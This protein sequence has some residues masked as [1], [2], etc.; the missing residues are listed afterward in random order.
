MVKCIECGTEF[1]EKTG[2][3]P[4]CGCPI[5]KQPD[6][7]PE[8]FINNSSND[9]KKVIN[10]NI[11]ISMCAIIIIAITIVVCVF[12]YK[13]N[14]INNVS[15]NGDLTELQVSDGLDLSY[16][17]TPENA[18]VKNVL[19]ESSDIGIASVQDGHVVAHK[20]GECTISVEINSKVKAE[21]QI[22]VVSKEEQQKEALSKL[23]S[24]VEEHSDFTSDG[25][26]MITVGSID[27]ETQF[28][29]G[30]KG[31]DIY[32][33]CEKEPV[34][35]TKDLSCD[36]NTYVVIKSGDTESASFKQYNTIDVL[37]YKAN[38]TGDGII[39]IN[40]YKLGNKVIIDSF[41]SSMDNTEGVETG[42]TDDFQKLADNGVK[43]DFDQLKKY[44]EENDDIGC[45]IEDLQLSHIYE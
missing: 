31:K 40:D 1:D 43:N 25:V 20:P 15:L 44:L 34:E 21:Y 14:Q 12:F 39:N 32:L 8:S 16:T 3:C 24:F 28:Y 11:I 35:N 18:K 41:K 38:S 6:V 17:V 37:G 5:T 22:S 2:S 23:V 4:E 29:I 33:I 19:W 36:Y 10:K 27:K 26:S 30:S 7:V 9:N 45:T 13:K 42:V